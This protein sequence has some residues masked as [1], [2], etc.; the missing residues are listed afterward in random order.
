MKYRNNP[1]NDLKY[2]QNI[3]DKE[4]VSR[5]CKNEKH[6]TTQSGLI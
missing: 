5:I 2:L 4:L 3:S 6:P 1:Q